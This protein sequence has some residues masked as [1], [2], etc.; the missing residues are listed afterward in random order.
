MS[1][2][3]PPRRRARGLAPYLLSLPGVLWLAVFFVVP[4]VT[5]FSVSLQE[6]TID[7]GFRFTGRWQNYTEQ[8]SAYSEHVVRS[9]VYG[10]IVTI[11][12]LLI[13][14]PMMYWIAFKGG[15]RK[16]L[17]LLLMLLPFFTPFLIRTLSWTFV[18]ADRGI[19]L[20]TLKDAGLLGDDFRLLATHVSVVAG[21]IYNF[22]PFMA[23]PLYVALERLDPSLLDA[24]HD[25]Y[26]SR[27]QA[28]VRVTLP[29]S[30]PGVFA[31]SLLT[32]IPSVGDFIDAELLG[33]VNNQM[34]GNVVERLFNDTFDYPE[35]AAISFVL[36]A[37]I[38]AGVF[39]YARAL[40]TEE[41]T[42]GEART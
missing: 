37:G 32:F 11:A 6:G 18:L 15:R 22:L 24:A 39:L 29:L 4:M 38:L 28:F 34:I 41:L 1:A 27:V 3:A 26:S 36:I 33:G 42:G 10:L 5:M 14:Y 35:G 31:G 9:L 7:T 2:A 21:M 20:G 17:F 16:N 19:V 12:T 23:L 40:G 25:L 30:L 13:S 8:L